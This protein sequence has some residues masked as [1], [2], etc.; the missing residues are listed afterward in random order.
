MS[1]LFD[2]QINPGGDMTN[3]NANPH[4]T[5][6]TLRREADVYRQLQPIRTRDLEQ[7]VSAFKSILEIARNWSI[8]RVETPRILKRNIV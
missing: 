2:T 3:L 1:S 5:L 7:V 6:E 8:G 4:L